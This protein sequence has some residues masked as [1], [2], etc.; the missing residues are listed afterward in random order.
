MFTPHLVTSRGEGGGQVTG[1]GAK[2]TPRIGHCFILEVDGE[3]TG[4]SSCCF[5][6]ESKRMRSGMQA[7]LGRAEGERES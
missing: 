7:G 6:F 3:C 5:S 1:R 4:G 2:E